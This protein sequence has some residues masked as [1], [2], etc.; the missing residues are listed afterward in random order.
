MQAQ[1][2]EKMFRLEDRYWWFVGRRRLALRLLRRGVA[3]A[4]RPRIL[5]LGCGTGRVMSELKEW[6]EPVGLDMSDLALRFSASRGLGPLVK[7]SGTALPFA[8]ERF[9][10]IVSLDVYE[11]IEDHR[12][13]FA[14]SLR[15]LKPGGTLVLS[16]PAHGFLWGPHDVALMHFR[17]YT[18]PELKA[19]LEAQGFEVE[20]IGYSVF[21]LFPVV[22]LVRFFER[23][24]K[25]PAQ[26][27]LVAVP[28]WLNRALVA[29]QTF[30]AS[31]IERFDLPWGS[32][33]IVVARKP[34]GSS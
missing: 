11:H 7:G 14:E 4:S 8:A 13:A 2:Y 21:F 22:M 20:R 26:A 15:V 34:G 29:L 3:G 18:R 24:R 23:R 6:S 33:V 30:E 25:G 16:V 19:L 5:D 17:R 31:L 12:R 9:D 28:E 10:A 1:E 32:S 27:N